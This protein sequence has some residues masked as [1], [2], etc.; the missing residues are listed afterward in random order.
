MLPSKESCRVGLSSESRRAGWYALAITRGDSMDVSRDPADLLAQGS[1]RYQHALLEVFGNLNFPSNCF[2]I[3]SLG[4]DLREVMPPS[5][6]AARNRV[7]CTLAQQ[8]SLLHFPQVPNLVALMLEYM[9]ELEAFV[10]MVCNSCLAE[11]RG[12]LQLWGCSL[13]SFF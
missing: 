7:I 2:R 8:Y 11:N 4:G 12:P 13:C 10:A 1:S 5:R 3:P 9:P 6:L